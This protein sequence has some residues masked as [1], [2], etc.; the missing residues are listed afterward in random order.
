[1]GLALLNH[2]MFSGAQECR[3]SLSRTGWDRHEVEIA[4]KVSGYLMSR[5]PQPCMRQVG[6]RT[7][8]SVC[9]CRLTQFGSS[10]T[11]MLLISE[12]TGLGLY[13]VSVPTIVWL[14]IYANFLLKT[15]WLSQSIEETCQRLCCE[16]TEKPICCSMILVSPSLWTLGQGHWFDISVPRIG[17]W[18]IGAQ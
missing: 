14:Y 2:L 13:V 1:M 12:H 5:M 3:R 7:P 11:I 18:H 17:T 8:G 9:F 4:V 10:L 15:L 6:H 16:M